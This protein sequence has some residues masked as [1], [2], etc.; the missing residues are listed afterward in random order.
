MSLQRAGSQAESPADM[1]L[2]KNIP[3]LPPKRE[4]FTS[5][6]GRAGTLQ[7]SDVIASHRGDRVGGS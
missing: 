5:R 3:E 6:R 7:P 1:V 2:P 4:F